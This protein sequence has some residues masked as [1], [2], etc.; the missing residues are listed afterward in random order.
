VKSLSNLGVEFITIHANGG[1]KMMEAAVRG[2]K[3]TRA[4]LLAVTELTSIDQK[5]LEAEI[6]IDRK[7]E[8]VVYRYAVNALTAGVHG[9]ICS[10]HESKYIKEKISN[11]LIC[12]TPGIRMNE[13][14]NDQSRTLTPRE[15]RANKAD[16]IVVGR[17][18]T[19]ADNSIKTYHLYK[20]EFLGE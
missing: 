4:K 20:R 15:A 6:L 2:V 13:N 9:V 8:D 5:T 12:I 11:N 19:N 18:I 3:G 10:G 7:L 14:K 16:F 17:P 1:I